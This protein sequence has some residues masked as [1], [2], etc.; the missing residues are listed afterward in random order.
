MRLVLKTL[1]RSAVSRATGLDIVAD[2]LESRLR[3]TTGRYVV[4]RVNQRSTLLGRQLEFERQ[5]PRIVL[6]VNG[7]GL[8]RYSYWMSKR[9]PALVTILS[10]CREDVRGLAETTDGHESGPGIVSYCGKAGS[11]LVPDHDFIESRGYAN[12]RLAALNAP[13]FE[14][15]ADVVLWRGTTTGHGL[16]ALAQMNVDDLRLIQRTRMCLAL[17]DVPGCDARLTQAVGTSDPERDNALLAA[18]GLLGSYL[19]PERWANVRYHVAVDGFT[20]A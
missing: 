13:A 16:I 15:R 12:I 14:D 2:L 11:V 17:R 10:A 8:D 5:G 6:T 19:P 3:A 1:V 18:A 4:V 9:L 20:L 7:S